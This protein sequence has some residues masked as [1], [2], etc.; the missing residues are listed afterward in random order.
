MKL[1]IENFRKF[2]KEE[3]SKLDKVSNILS[4]PGTSLD[5]YVSVLKRYAKDPTFD[6][7]A[8][9]GATDGDPNDEVVTVKPATVAAGSLTATQSEIGF[10]NSLGDQVINKYDATKTALGLNGTPIAMSSKSGPSPL[11]VFNGK[12][13]LDGHHRWSQ[14]MMVNPTGDVLIDN[15]TGPAL[16]DEEQA[17]KAMQFA[18]AA[19]ADQV[20]TKPFE[21]KDLMGSSEDEVYQFVMENVSDEVLQLLVMAKKIQKPSKELAARYIASNLDVIKARKGKFSRERSMPQA[22]DSG[23]SQDAVNKALGTGKVNFIEPEPSDAQ[24]QGKELGVAGSGGTDSGYKKSGVGRKR[25][26]KDA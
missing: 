21:G 15:V 20:V 16:D 7:L 12:F 25:R 3:E 17:L 18:I 22:G 24:Q 13:I 9:A 11:L 4:N 5:Q 10:G 6:K 1:L 23:V 19:T 2:I 26:Q 8:S 14:V